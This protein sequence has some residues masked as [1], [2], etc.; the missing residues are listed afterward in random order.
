MDL[1]DDQMLTACMRRLTDLDIHR[2]MRSM[3]R[4]LANAE[5]NVREGNVQPYPR[6]LDSEHIHILYSDIPR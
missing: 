1:Y 2:F 6:M 4:M 3:E 5:Q